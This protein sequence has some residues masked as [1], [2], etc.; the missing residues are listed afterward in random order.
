M[1]TEADGEVSGSVEPG[2]VKVRSM[3]VYVS[4]DADYSLPSKSVIKDKKLEL[5]ELVGG[6]T[7]ARTRFGPATPDEEGLF[8]VALKGAVQPIV[9]IPV[10]TRD[11]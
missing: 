6:Y 2:S 7:S 10:E 8:R 4:P 11:L 9:W 3:A 5:V 1:E